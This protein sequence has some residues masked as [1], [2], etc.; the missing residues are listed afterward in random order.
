MPTVIDS[1]IVKFGLDKTDFDKGSKELGSSLD[2]TKQS[3]AKSFG[4]VEQS[5]KQAAEAVTRVAREVMT[6]LALFTGGRAVKSFVEDIT[7]A[8]SALGYLARNLNTAPGFLSA[9]GQAVEQVGGSSGDAAQSFR[10]FSD[11]IQELKVNGN[12]GMLEW[13]YKLQNASGVF[14]DLNKDLKSQAID[15]STAFSNIAKTDPVR[16]SWYARQRFGE[17]TAN[18]LLQGPEKVSAAL[19]NTSKHALSK[20]DTDAA[21]RL[22]R[23]WINLRQESEYLGNK[24]ATAL[25]P[26]VVD[27]LEKLQ[28]WIAA[29]REWIKTEIVKYVKEFADWLKSINWNEVSDGVKAF[30]KGADSAARAIGGWGSATKL[31]FELWLGAKFLSVLANLNLLRAALG[32]AP[33]LA[34]AAAGGAYFALD[35]DA[36]KRREDAGANWGPDSVIRRGYGAIKRWFGGGDG[37]YGATGRGSASKAYDLIK[38]VGG[39]DEEARILAAISQAESAGNP[40]AHNP[41]AATGDNSYGLWQINMLGRMGPERRAKFGLN[42]NEDLYDPETNARVALAMKR[43]AGGYQ[44]WST[45]KNG[46]YRSHLASA[47]PSGGSG[48]GFLGSAQAAPA[49]RSGSPFGGVQYGGP[50]SAVNNSPTSNFTNSSS[51]TN[52][53]TINAHLPNVSD[54]SG[55]ARDL[56]PMLLQNDRAN[57]I[58]TGPQ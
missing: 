1:L 57:M 42:S 38:K 23:T 17:G 34:G 13:L 35:S 3:A 46:A 27:L 25:S 19:A 16:A 55:F 6:L 21:E 58:N 48:G 4:Q 31:L 8:N 40:R 51:T 56:R 5:G 49:K 2:K 30:A 24:I 18:F 36:T 33:I 10:A 9:F 12:S 52:I 14:F 50:W 41:N 29:N 11:S 20:E 44:D 32:M 28:S 22:L 54:A 39:T 53:G 45:Y 15:F 7:S 26:I 47:K 37:G 43:A